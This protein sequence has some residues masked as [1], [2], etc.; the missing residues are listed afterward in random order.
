MRRK[1]PSTNAL[2]AFEAA[3]RH[4]SFSRAAE[5]L[6]MTEGAVSR[7]IARLE[8]FLG[9]MLFNR[10]KGRLHLTDR[11]RD[12]L[13]QITEDLD[14]VELHT[15]RL[16]ALPERG[17]LELAVIPT[18]TNKWIIPRLPHFHAKNPGILINMSERPEPF[19]FSETSFDAA[20]HYDHPAW[21]GMIK[22]NIF[23]EELIA[24]CSPRLAG[25]RRA[26]N[27]DE[28]KSLP[29]LHKRSRPYAWKKWWDHFGTSGINPTE[30]AQYDLFS[31][32]IEAACAGLGVALVPRLYVNNEIERGDLITPHTHRLSGE[33]SYCVVFPEH[34]HGSWPLTPFLDWLIHESQEYIRQRAVHDECLSEPVSV[35]K[36]PRRPA[37]VGGR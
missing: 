26:L 21:T 32:A 15:Q 18:F 5:E 2:L 25:G 3:G 20:I 7:Q 11:G 30:G 6:A 27:L 4:E 34:K 36:A 29:R 31:M 23:S 35:R 37:I 1:I 24:V 19:L 8:D 16:Q 28:M 22:K 33:K 17:V 10:V 13:V 14:R 12:Y 9:L